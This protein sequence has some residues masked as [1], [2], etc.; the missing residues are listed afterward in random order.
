MHVMDLASQSKHRCVSPRTHT[1]IQRQTHHSQLSILFIAQQHVGKL[2]KQEAT[3]P[4][5]S[6]KCTCGDGCGCQD[7]ASSNIGGGLKKKERKRKRCYC[8]IDFSITGLKVMTHNITGINKSAP[9][10]KPKQPDPACVQTP[11]GRRCEGT[12]HSVPAVL[13]YELLEN[14]QGK[15]A[16]SW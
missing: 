14:R 5:S 6:P 9:A 11:V 2:S 10:L 3:W 16:H 15:K 13:N 1:Q 8:Q 7:D 12:K 4:A